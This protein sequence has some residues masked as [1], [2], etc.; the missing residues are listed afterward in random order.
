MQTR[1]KLHDFMEES[2][3]EALYK[4]PETLNPKLNYRKTSPLHDLQLNISGSGDSLFPCRL[5]TH[6]PKRP[7]PRA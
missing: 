4:P 5:L 3:L 7:T 1:T 6:V 2:P